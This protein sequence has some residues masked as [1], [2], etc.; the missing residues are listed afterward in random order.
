VD[1][2]RV[3]AVAVR[4]LEACPRAP[5]SYHPGMPAHA[6]PRLG[7][8]V[9]FFAT[10]IIEHVKPAMGLAAI[11]VLERLG[12]AVQVPPD[13]T[14]CGQPAF[15]A[16]AREDARHMARQTIDV[17]SQSDLPVVGYPTETT[18]AFCDGH[19]RAFAFFGGVPKSILYDNTRIAVARIP[20][21]GKRQR[22]RVFAELQSHY[23]FEDR[24]GRPG[25]TTR[26]KSK[27]LSATRD[28]TF[29]CPSRCSRASRH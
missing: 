18:E 17:L 14:C 27:V 2:R 5:V 7:G 15:N 9:Q 4:Q 25:T 13:Q 10:C 11:R 28:G 8:T 1:V 23:L 3:A 21:G 6:P 29:S 22:T 20:G 26:G 24:F 19:V 12:L 16:G